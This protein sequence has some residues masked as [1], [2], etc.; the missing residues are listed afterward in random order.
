MTKKIINY[1]NDKLIQ[2]TVFMSIHSNELP[3]IQL[4]II[5]SS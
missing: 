2:V 1:K 4:E 3:V 5:F